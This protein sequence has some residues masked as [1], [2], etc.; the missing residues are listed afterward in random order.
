[1]TAPASGRYAS[2]DTHGG[3]E[4]ATRALLVLT[5][6]GTPAAA[7]RLARALVSERLAACVN[8]ID[9]V[10]SCYRWKG[11][12]EE[13]DE[14]L[15]VIKTTEDRYAAVERAIRQQSDYELPEVVAVGVERGL[16]DYLAWIRESLEKA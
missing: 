9:G 16:P 13:A 7:E 12:V 2:E 15:L 6:C 14:S 11:E 10:T 1:M 3:F 5:T 8:R 4:V